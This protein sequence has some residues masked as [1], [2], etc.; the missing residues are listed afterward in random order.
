MA[1]PGGQE[2][3]WQSRQGAQGRVAEQAGKVALMEGAGLEANPAF[4]TVTG[5]NSSIV[6]LRVKLD[7][8]RV[9]PTSFSSAKQQIPSKSNFYSA[10]G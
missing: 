1:G 4:H 9:G 6:C 2:A 5:H 10:A 3:Q 7:T 8:V